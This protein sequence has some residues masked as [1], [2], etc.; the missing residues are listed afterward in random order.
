[1]TEKEKK[2]NWRYKWSNRIYKGYP[3]C[4]EK[5]SHYFPTFT[6]YEAAMGFQH[7][8]KLKGD[9]LYFLPGIVVI[10]DRKRIL[11]NG[12]Y[13]N[14]GMLVSRRSSINCTKF[15]QYPGS[16]ASLVTL[17]KSNEIRLGN[18]PFRLGVFNPEADIL[19]SKRTRLEGHLSAKNWIFGEPKSLDVD[20]ELFERE[21]PLYHVTMSRQIILWQEGM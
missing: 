7:S 2:D 12:W 18:T 20:S 10:N 1:R 6:Q 4:R 13:A 21:K 16:L 15:I 3:F 9:K 8:T 11:L 14:R 17:G 5:A 19:T